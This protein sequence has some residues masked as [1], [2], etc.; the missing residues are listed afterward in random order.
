M[1]ER[2]E[3]KRRVD[4]FVAMIPP[5][6]TFQSKQMT[7]VGGKPRMFDS[8]ELKAVRLRLLA[9][10]APYAPARP[11]TGA[12]QLVTKWCWPAD[13]KRGAGGYKATKPDTDN[14]IKALKDAMTKAGYWHDDAQV[15]SEVTE[16][17]W[18]DVPGIYVMV[19][20]L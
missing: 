11:L 18:A 9:E 19:R 14:L 2:T 5:T 20:E 13:G 1:V 3:P 15:A 6:T 12:V 10:V 17:F 4:F 7:V 8:P 16:K